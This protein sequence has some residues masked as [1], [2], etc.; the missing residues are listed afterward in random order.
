NRT[1]SETATRRGVPHSRFP[2]WRVSGGE[3]LRASVGSTEASAKEP[4]GSMRACLLA[5]IESRTVT[6]PSCFGV[7]GPTRA[8]SDDRAPDPHIG[9]RESTGP[10]FLRPSPVLQPQEFD[11]PVSG[12]P[13]LGVRPPGDLIPLHVILHRRRRPRQPQ[14]RLPQ[15]RL[16]QPHRPVTK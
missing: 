2:H 10:C 4:R 15:R 11:T 8:R 16:H 13:G 14:L 7:V 1:F 3:V 9:A 6:A 12:P 5:S